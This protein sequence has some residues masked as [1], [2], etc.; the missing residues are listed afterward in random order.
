M[1]LTEN[2]RAAGDKA[3]QYY[4]TRRLLHY[5]PTAVFEAKLR[6]DARATGV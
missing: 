3:G 4:D 2:R 5:V 1:F 6:S